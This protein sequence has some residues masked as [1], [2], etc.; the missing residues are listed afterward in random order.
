MSVASTPVAK[1]D[2]L[3]AVPA[4][5][6]AQ[7]LAPV[8]VEAPQLER[9]GE[10]V[11][12]LLARIHAQVTGAAE[13][14]RVDAELLWWRGA[15]SRPLIECVERSFAVRQLCLRLAASDGTWRNAL[16]YIGDTDPADETVCT[17]DYDRAEIRYTESSA[18]ASPYGWTGPTGA[19]VVTWYARTGMSAILAWLIATSR[20]AQDAGRR[21][22]VLTNRL[23]HETA[24]LFELTRLEWVE[25]RVFDDCD[26]IVAAADSVEAPAVVF[27]DSSRPDGDVHAVRRILREVDPDRMGC[28]VWDN[29]CAPA[30]D[31]PFGDG[32]A[33]ERMGTALLLLRSHAKLDQLG[34]E[35]CALGTAALMSSPAATAAARAVVDGL[36]NYLPDALAVSGGC[37]SPPTLRLLAALGLPEQALA[38]RA[39]RVLRSANVLGG[40]LLRAVLEPGGR[41]VI[42]E[43]EHRCFVEI[44]VLD[45]PGPPDFGA[46][47]VW[48]PWASF[49]QLLTRVEQDGAALAVP[50]WKS[51]SFGFHYTGLSWYPAEDEPF[52]G[53]FRHTVLR[54][55][56]GMHDPDVV[57]QVVDI[58]AAHLLGRVDWVEGG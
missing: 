20:L 42:E 29:T 23:Y 22:T 1:Y 55:C 47:P 11:G 58:V 50:I 52:P 25:V 5:V 32:I 48:A 45:L 7:V 41:Y 13:R 10:E 15:V 14:A 39:N 34:L 51:A 56:F 18:L 26:G 57:G 17:Y 53:G 44:H 21:C 28:L 33:M 40:Q 4:V 3:G 16:S 38:V 49:D 37:A 36:T 43:N 6:P 54:L 30:E 12:Y 9:L 19:E 24:I 31:H 35:F 46:P 8:P 2:E 27:L